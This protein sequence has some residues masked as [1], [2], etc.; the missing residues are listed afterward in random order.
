[1]SRRREEEKKEEEKKDSADVGVTAV[2]VN[3]GAAAATQLIDSGGLVI[4][5]AVW[6]AATQLIVKREEMNAIIEEIDTIKEMDGKVDPG[7][8]ALLASML[9][10]I[11]ELEA[12]VE[13]QTENLQDMWCVNGM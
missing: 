13:D 9:E 10:E 5:N 3:D 4:P 6:G 7:A 2:Q 11:A 1:M 8:E 12:L